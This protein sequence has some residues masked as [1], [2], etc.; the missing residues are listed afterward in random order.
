MGLGN[1]EGHLLFTLTWCFLPSQLLVS[2]QHQEM[3]FEK[4][5]AGRKGDFTLPNAVILGLCE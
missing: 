5:L 1:N 4:T 2:N 3:L